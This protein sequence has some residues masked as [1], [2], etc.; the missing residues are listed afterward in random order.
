MMKYTLKTQNN[1]S[2]MKAFKKVEF[3]Y[4][5]HLVS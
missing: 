2:I 3:P 4:V 1:K 5:L